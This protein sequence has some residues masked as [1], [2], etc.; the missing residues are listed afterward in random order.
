MKYAP[1]TE[2]EIQKML[3]VIGISSVDSLFSDIE[4]KITGYDFDNG[5]SEFEVFEKIK[6]LSEKN[7]ILMNFTGGGFYNHYIP[8]AV[9]SLSSDPGFY[10]SYTPYQP[11]CSQ[12]TLQALYEYQTSVC[13]LTGMD[14]S[15]ASV[16]DG[17]TALAE[18]S[19]MAA[20]IT[21]RRKIVLDSGINPL[22]REIIKTYLRNLEVE[23]VEIE[24]ENFSLSRERFIDEIDQNTAAFIAQNPNFFGTVDDYS[25]I[26][27]KAHEN[28]AL[29]VIAPYPVS[30][31]ILKNPAEMG[32]DITAGEGQS[33]GNPLNFGGP[34]LGFIASK[35]KYIRKLPGRIV[36][37]TADSSGKRGFVLT[38]QARE[39]HIKRQKATSNI[40]TNQ[41]LCAIRALIYM[42]CLG[43]EGLKNLAVNCHSKAVY[44]QEQLTSIK[45]VETL[46]QNIFNEFVLKLPH[47]SKS[48]YREMLKEGI[49]FGLPLSE[50]YPEKEHELLVAVTEKNTCGQIDTVKQKLKEI[51]S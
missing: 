14:V 1:H 29:S 9:D 8:A 7:S 28:G 21:G 46:N 12:G 19:L 4:N 5:K 51:L 2:K 31:G 20:R 6:G 50:F 41:N 30:L 47:N 38:L 10:T 35:R 15:N 17:G 40:C 32:A 37:K 33:L 45:G 48:V 49:S 24:A 34:Y 36:G 16:Y 11:E 39:Q 27:E 44:A 43:K 23:T 26:S 22:Y 3:N 13:R 25:D 42:S 18:A